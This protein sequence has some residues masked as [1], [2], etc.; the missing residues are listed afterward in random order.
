MLE[1]IQRLDATVKSLTDSFV[2]V[3]ERLREGGG[4]A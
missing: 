3:A 2:V 1:Q 4:G